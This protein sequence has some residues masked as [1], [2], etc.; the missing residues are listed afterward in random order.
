VGLE[1]APSHKEYDHITTTPLWLHITTSVLSTSSK[2]T[3]LAATNYSAARSTFFY[4]TRCNYQSSSLHIPT[5]PIKSLYLLPSLRPIPTNHVA[6]YFTTAS[7]ILLAVSCR[8]LLLAP[9]RPAI[10]SLNI[11]KSSFSL[12]TVS[13]LSPAAA[14]RSSSFLALS[15]PFLLLHLYCSTVDTLT[16]FP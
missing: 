11:Y 16:A 14:A 4:W 5:Y 1:L 13:A 15:Q 2:L 3:P 10:F 9:D 7:R 6:Q 8:F 12:L